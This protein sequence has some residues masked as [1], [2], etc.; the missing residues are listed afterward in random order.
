[1]RPP[2]AK[3]EAA[4]AFISNCN[5]RTFRLAALQQLS[6]LLP[7][8][9]FGA[10]LRS[11]QTLEP[12]VAA[13]RRYHFALAFENSQ[14]DFY[15]LLSSS[16]GIGLHSCSTCMQGN[17]SGIPSSMLACTRCPGAWPG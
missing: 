6:E 1:M 8:H 4:A 15:S 3:Q 13:L 17:A 9:S 7:V 2:E 10:C 14:V 12:K 11:N 16:P 5:S